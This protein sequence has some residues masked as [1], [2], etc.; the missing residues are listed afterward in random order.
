[1]SPGSH[2]LGSPSVLGMGGQGGLR[3]AQKP[4]VQAVQVGALTI[5]HVAC[6]RFTL[7]SLLLTLDPTGQQAPLAE[8]DLC[9]RAPWVTARVGFPCLTLQGAPT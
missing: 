3:Q 1:M 7:L 2:F 8:Q 9:F 6:V 5:T 4:A